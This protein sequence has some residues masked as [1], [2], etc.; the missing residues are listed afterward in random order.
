M[1][2]RT[3]KLIL[4]LAAALAAAGCNGQPPERTTEADRVAKRIDDGYHR[5]SVPPTTL[6]VPA[7]KLCAVGEDIVVTLRIL[8][9][10][11]DKALDPYLP[12]RGQL[13]V[14]RD[15]SAVELSPLPGAERLAWAELP[16]DRT[17]QRERSFSLTVNRIFP[18]DRTGWYAIWWDGRDD[19]GHRLSSGENYVRVMV[20]VPAE[21]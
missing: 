4:A 15:G 20:R 19:L 13:H 6:L 16:A 7:R 12:I 2:G 11:E 9:P 18:M 14:K 3:G 8:S 10:E 1:A 17:R 5:T 21:E